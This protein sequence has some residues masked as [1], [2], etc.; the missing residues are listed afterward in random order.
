MFSKHSGELLNGVT[1]ALDVSFGHL[2]VPILKNAY[3]VAEDTII[4]LCGKHIVEYDII[5]K[6]QTYIMKQIDDQ[7]I[8]AMNFYI[9]KKRVIQIAICLKSTSKLAPRYSEVI[10]I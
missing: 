9:S 4:Y 10:I 5:R 8:S 3:F 1:L 6:K 7:A 2:Q